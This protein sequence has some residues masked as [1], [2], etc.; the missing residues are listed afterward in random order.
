M[1]LGM[2]TTEEMV[3]REGQLTNGSLSDYK[4][5]TLL[6]VPHHFINEYVDS[7]QSDGPFGA[8][9]AGETASISLSP[10]IGNAIADAIGLHIKDLP[11]TPEAVY[12]A[13][14]SHRGTAS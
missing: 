5:P 9:G 13:M 14:Q 10:A 2:T 6:D 8:K 7:R 11:L 4:I 12:R 1:Q 3:Y